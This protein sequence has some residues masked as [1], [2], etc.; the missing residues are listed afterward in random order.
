MEDTRPWVER[1]FKYTEHEIAPGLK[2]RHYIPGHDCEVPDCI[3]G[4]KHKTPER[5]HDCHQYNQ[6][7]QMKVKESRDGGHEFYSIKRG[8]RDTVSVKKIAAEGKQVGPE[9]K[10]LLE[11]KE[12]ALK[13]GNGDEA[14]KIRRQLRKL[15]YKRYTQEEEEKAPSKGKAVSKKATPSNS[16]GRI[17]TAARVKP[18]TNNGNSQAARG[19]KVLEHITKSAK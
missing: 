2:V 5:A 11:Q 7:W 15:G 12:A 8:G 6:T 4:R 3:E 1:G 9:V 18:P 14:R 19:A 10:R 13:A 17:K 16:K